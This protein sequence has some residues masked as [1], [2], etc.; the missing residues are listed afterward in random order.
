MNSFF[1]PALK[2]FII[3]AFTLGMGYS[4]W[5]LPND[6]KEDRVKKER[7]ITSP[8]DA[9]DEAGRYLQQASE[10]FFYHE[11]DKAIE[12]Y[13]K[14]ITVFE[15]ENQLKK[16]AKVYESIGDLYK[17]RRNIKQAEEQ[18][19]LAIEYHH[20]IKNPLGEAR[21]MNH[22]GD[23]LM[24]QG[25]TVSA[26]AWYKKGVQ[27]VKEVP[28]DKIQAQLFENM[29]RFYWKTE[30]NIPEAIVWYTRARDTFSTLENQMGYDHMSAVLNKLRG[31][32]NLNTH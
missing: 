6:K 23:L 24:E 32:Q 10:D 27:L 25:E 18:Y 13:G 20:R 11:F 30:E 14:A 28:P 22:A 4:V 21:A 7:A 29:G 16:A 1:K 3:F 5:L 19:I 2:Y 8:I 12:N 26:G 31:G 17:F 9:R 15:K